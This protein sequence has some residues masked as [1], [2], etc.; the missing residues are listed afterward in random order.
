MKNSLTV[1]G[2]RSPVK[3][4]SPLEMPQFL[5]TEDPPQLRTP[6]LE[7]CSQAIYQTRLSCHG[8]T[9]MC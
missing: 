5:P 4:D 1:T 8:S 3:L 2:T 9:E 7:H 6:E